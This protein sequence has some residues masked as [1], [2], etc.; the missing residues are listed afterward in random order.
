MKLQ[1]GDI[2]LIPFPFSDLSSSKTRPAL[3]VSNR[4]LKGHDVILCAITSQS[5]SPQEL[6]LSNRDLVRGA[7]PVASFIRFGKLASLDRA[8][9]RKRVAKVK[10]SKMAEVLEEI[11]VLL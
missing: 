5:R 7:L 1:Q 9:V 11:K 10:N 6:P 4:K 2:V 3:V 8:I